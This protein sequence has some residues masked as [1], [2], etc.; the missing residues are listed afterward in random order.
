MERLPDVHLVP[1]ADQKLLTS[2]E[3]AAAV[4][5]GGTFKH[6]LAMEYR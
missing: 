4:A 3:R 5:I 1:E 6:L 2:A